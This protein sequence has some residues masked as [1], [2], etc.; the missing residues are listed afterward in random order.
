LSQVSPVGDTSGSDGMKMDV[1]T[2]GRNGYFY[3]PI[4]DVLKDIIINQDP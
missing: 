1:K 2:N 4:D 3:G